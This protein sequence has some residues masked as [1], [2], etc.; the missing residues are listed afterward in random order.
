MNKKIFCFQWEQTVGCTGCTGN[1]GVC[2]K[3]K[4]EKK[5]LD[6]ASYKA[7]SNLHLNFI[8]PFYSPQAPSNSLRNLPAI[9]LAC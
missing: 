1:T 4:I 5:R 9:V 3:G 8:S 6:A 7:A 2:G